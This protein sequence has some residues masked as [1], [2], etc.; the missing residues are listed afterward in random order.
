[1]KSLSQLYY[2]AAGTLA[3]WASVNGSAATVYD[4]SYSGQGLPYYYAPT[5]YGDEIV[6]AGTARALTGFHFAYYSDY[7]LADGLSFT[8]YQNDGPLVSGYPSPGTVL[9]SGSYDV[10]LGLSGVD[11]DLAFTADPGNPLPDRLTFVAE[12]LGGGVAGLLVAD[13]PTIGASGDDFWQWTA[14]SWELRQ[15]DGYTSNF[16][17]TITAAPVPEATPGVATML[18]LASFAG[19]ARLR[20]RI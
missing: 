14:G 18:A 12:F 10:T 15:L 4:A 8:L 16:E 1:M 9:F 13:V 3:L 6:L 11:I 7:A 20:R 2:T 5:A 19:I 17:A